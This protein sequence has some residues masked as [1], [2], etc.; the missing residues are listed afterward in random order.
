MRFSWELGAGSWELGA[1][2]KTISYLP[3][4]GFP[5]PK[6]RLSFTVVLFA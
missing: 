4:K 5:Y 6:Q 2:D 3:H 1:E